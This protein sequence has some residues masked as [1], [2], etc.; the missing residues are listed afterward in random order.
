MTTPTRATTLAAALRAL[1][2]DP[3]DPSAQDTARL[4]LAAYDTAV[5]NVRKGQVKAEKRTKPFTVDGRRF[6]CANTAFK[7]AQQEGFDGASAVF[8][9]RVKKGLPWADCIKP[10][11]PVRANARR[12][13]TARKHAEMARS[14][15]EMNARRVPQDFPVRPIINPIG[16]PGAITC[17][18]C[19]LSWDNSIATSYTP[20]PSARC[21]FEA[22]HP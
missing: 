17:E 7:A 21:P 13:S 18:T 3:N 15:A 10:V 11:D 9:A 12:N 16:V 8:I 2:A 6:T 1:L 19:H 14:L 5:A 22:F 20:T 4:E